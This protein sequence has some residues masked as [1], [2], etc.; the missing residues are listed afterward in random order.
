[1]LHPTPSPRP[2]S[3]PERTAAVLGGIAILG[4]V[5]TML[6]LAEKVEDGLPYASWR[7]FR[8]E[9]GL[10]KKE[11]AELL[12]IAP[13]TLDRR[14]QSGRLEPDESD[15]LARVAR[16]FTRAVDVLGSR[17]KARTWF[18]RPNRAL[19]QRKPTALLGTDAGA[20]EVDEVLGRIEH[21]IFS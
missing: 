13:R 12:R 18:E 17:E 6:E 8:H 11:L 16:I 10:P 15:R 20:R 21:G 1:M 19:G 7:A 5:E 2:L 14:Q 3:L 9:V 4:E